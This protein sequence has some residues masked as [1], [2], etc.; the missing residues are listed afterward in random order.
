[1]FKGFL[2]HAHIR[3]FSLWFGKCCCHP[4]GLFASAC[5]V[6]MAARKQNL[7]YF[8]EDLSNYFSR[9]AAI[10]PVCIL[11]TGCVMREVHHHKAWDVDAMCLRRLL[12][13]TLLCVWNCVDFCCWAPKLLWTKALSMI[14]DI[15]AD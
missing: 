3:C 15:C 2:L 5:F 6:W 1:L 14:A 12:S 7:F 9:L 8:A 4:Q 13:C 10:L 11:D